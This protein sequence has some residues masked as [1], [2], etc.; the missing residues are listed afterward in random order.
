MSDAKQMMFAKN[1]IS[2]CINGSKNGDFQGAL[3]HQ[4]ADE[5]IPFDS[6][7]KLL[8]LVDELL[9]EWDFP[10][11]SLDPRTFK[12][13]NV[14]RNTRRTNSEDELVIDKIQQA[15]GTRNIQK[16]S[17]ELGTFIVQ[18]V[19]RQNATWQGQV[20]MVETNEK[21]EFSSAMELLRIMDDSLKSRGVLEI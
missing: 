14:V 15:Y 12:A 9:D 21:K 17:G 5:P 18:I 6:V 2:V 19:Y 13:P 3:Y 1:L 20:L 16:Q 7:I 4:Y 11:K 8:I 10:Q